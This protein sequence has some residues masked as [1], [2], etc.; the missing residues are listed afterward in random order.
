MF[1]FPRVTKRRV[2]WD[3]IVCRGAFVRAHAAL[4]TLNAKKNYFRSDFTKPVSLSV[5]LK[6]KDI[7]PTH[8]NAEFL[9]V[10]QSNYLLSQINKLQLS[11]ILF[12]SQQ[13]GASWRETVV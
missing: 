1:L 10:L 5:L 12:C 3:G 8:S 6:K 13:P 2:K 11:L 4:S 9:K 7:H